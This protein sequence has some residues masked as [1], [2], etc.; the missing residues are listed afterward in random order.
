[1]EEFDEHIKKKLSGYSIDNYD[2]KKGW[3]K[4]VNKKSAKGGSVVKVSSWIAA[5]CVVIF[6]GVWSLNRGVEEKMN[7][8]VAKADPPLEESAP[9]ILAKAPVR[10]SVPDLEKEM[11]GVL[12]EQKHKS[13]ERQKRQNNGRVET[14]ISHNAGMESLE[15][16]I[17]TEGQDLKIP[18]QKAINQIP[19]PVTSENSS[20]RVQIPEVITEEQLASMI[21]SSGDS[22]TNGK[23]WM[24]FFISRGEQTEYA[25]TKYSSAPVSLQQIN[26][27]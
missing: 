6:A 1:M 10:E 25:G 3:S 27:R 7:V 23:K 5:A 17:V 13:Q 14:D 19:H 4:Y 8:P 20:N 22:E 11:P 15:L 2:N 21:L 12:R 16:S 9:S 18:E 26:L 24:T